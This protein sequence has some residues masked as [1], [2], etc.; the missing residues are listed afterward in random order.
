M[1]QWDGKDRLVG[2]DGKEN[3]V[4]PELK[5]LKDFGYIILLYLLVC[6][7]PRFFIAD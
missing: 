3:Q 1:D 2:E 4:T 6:V 5:V 7:G